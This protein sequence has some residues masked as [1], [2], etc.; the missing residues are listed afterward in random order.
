MS[1]LIWI[2]IAYACGS[3]PFGVLIARMKGV[4]IR[5]EGSGNIG[6][7]NVGRILGRKFGIVCFL[8]DAL[9]GGAPVLAAGIAQNTLGES[10]ATLTPLSAWGWL[11]T[12]VAAILGH[13]FSPWLGFK[14]GKGVATAFGGM[15]AIWPVMTIPVMIALL[16]WAIAL[17]TTRMM[18][19]ASIVA[20][21]V[22]PII[23]AVE[24]GVRSTLASGL[25]F[26]LVTLLLAGFVVLRHRR[27]IAR[28]HDGTEPTI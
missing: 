3:I 6:A 27:N 18:S 2:L 23:I 7:T 11:L 24:M 20:A 8:L 28:I 16:V 19:L 14:G 4:D 12:A 25:P 9:K 10:L 5:R 15:L 13:C 17:S 26:L 22:L 1:W 21:A